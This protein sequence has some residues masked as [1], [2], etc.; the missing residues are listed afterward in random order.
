MPANKNALIR[1]KTIDNCLRNRYRRWTIEDLVE[2][3]SEALYDMEG[4]TKG[5]SLRTVQGDLQ[6]MRSDKLGYYA[7]I[8]VYD[9]KYYRYSDPEYSITEMPLTQNDYDL[10]KEATDIL[11]QLQDFDQFAEIADVVGRLQDKLAITRKSRRPIIHFDS[12][13][14]LKGL[15]LLNPLYN[16]IVCQQTLRIHYQP[17]KADEPT[18]KVIYPYMLKEFRNRWFLLA[19]SADD[20]TL[21]NFA[22]DRIT[23]IEVMEKMPWRD[24]PAFDPENYFNDIIGVSKPVGAKPKAIKFWASPKESKYII[25]KPL[26]SSQELLEENEDGSCIFQIKLIINMELYSVFLSHGTGLK[27]LSPENSVKFMKSIIYKWQDLYN[28]VTL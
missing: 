11:G 13:C 15:N 1:Y 2:A 10:M 9:N 12:V 23:G 3:C 7:P 4:I 8:E 6:I 25:T 26:H 21:L 27:I 18:P 28:D 17:F 5:V 14:D 20:M 24:N 22:L 19:S 16:H